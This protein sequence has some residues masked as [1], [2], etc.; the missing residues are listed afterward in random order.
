MTAP[1]T[2][3]ITETVT[4]KKSSG[5][6]RLSRELALQGLY[7]YFLSGNSEK[8]IYIHLTEDP[9]FVK[10]DKSYCSALLHGA[11]ENLDGLHVKIGQFIDRKV[12]ELS[13]VE[14]AVLCIA[15]YE[16]AFDPSIPYRVVINEGI[17]LAKRYGGVDGHKYVNGVLDHMAADLRAKEFKPKSGAVKK[18]PTK[19]IAG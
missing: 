4:P 5:N 13:P 17:E 18:S 15:A 10:A 6:R 3:P 11:L 16:L 8:N 14:H 1:M 9:M 19:A 2:D 7:Q 12:E